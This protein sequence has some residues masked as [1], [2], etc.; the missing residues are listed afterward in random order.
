MDLSNVKTCELVKE[1]KRREGVL[2]A[3]A[4]PH[5]VREITVSGPAYI[6]III[7]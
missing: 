6:L 2:T 3:Y 1:L 4:E 7:D 5:K